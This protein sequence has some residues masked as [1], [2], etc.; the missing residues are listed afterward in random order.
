M[1]NIR[2]RR[3]GMERNDLRTSEASISV[4]SIEQDGV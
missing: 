3:L 1:P 2:Y 4:V